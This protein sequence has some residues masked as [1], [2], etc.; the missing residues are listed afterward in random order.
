MHLSRHLLNG[1]NS[2]K[3]NDPLLGS[4][5]FWLSFYLKAERLA[6]KVKNM[7]N[8][9]G[10]NVTKEVVWFL[11]FD[12]RFWF[13]WPFLISSVLIVGFMLMSNRSVWLTD[14]ELSIKEFSSSQLNCL[15]DLFIQEKLYICV[16]F[17]PVSLFI[18]WDEHFDYR[19]ESFFLKECFDVFFLAL[20]R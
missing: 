12:W 18:F 6:K 9:S 8:Q 11:V 1:A 5:S 15:F 16:S 19:T 3:N 10:K 7:K 14:Y 13:L 20:E 4:M 17:R 2:N